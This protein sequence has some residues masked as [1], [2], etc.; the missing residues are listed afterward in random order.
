MHLVI[1]SI[2]MCALIGSYPVVHDTLHARSNVKLPTWQL[3]L[4]VFW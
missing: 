3:H 4:N 1:Q 2:L